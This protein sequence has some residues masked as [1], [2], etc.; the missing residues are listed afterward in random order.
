LRTESRL[1]A[2]LD[3][4]CNASGLAALSAL[5][6]LGGGR[7]GRAEQQASGYGSIRKNAHGVPPLYFGDQRYIAD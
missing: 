4:R 1:A 5:G 6:L 7:N 3:A 2:I